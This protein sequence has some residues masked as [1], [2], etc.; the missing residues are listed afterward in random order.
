[1]STLADIIPAL[2]ALYTGKP[3]LT[4]V[5]ASVPVVAPEAADLPMLFFDVL[6]AI[7]EKASNHRR[8]FVWPI[9]I[10]LLVTNRTESASNDLTEV[11]PWPETLIGWLDEHVTLNGLL[12]A[13]YRLPDPLMEDLAPIRLL[14]KTW[15]GCILHPHFPVKLERTFG[16]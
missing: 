7:P 10:Y 4:T 16:A 1:M 11:Y 6:A 15:M 13:S 5:Q 3:G 12:A 14:K 9:D 8:Q 2:V